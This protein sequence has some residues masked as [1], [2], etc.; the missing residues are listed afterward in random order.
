MSGKSNGSEAVGPPELDP[1]GGPLLEFVFLA[2]FA[3]FAAGVDFF[4]VELCPPGP[5]DLSPR[6]SSRF[7]DLWYFG[8]ID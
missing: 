5:S 3:F 4:V 2:G 7:L 6:G 8:L 1:F